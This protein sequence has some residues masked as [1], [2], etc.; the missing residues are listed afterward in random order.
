MEDLKFVERLNEASFLQ[1][2]LVPILDGF[3]EIKAEGMVFLAKSKEN[4]LEQLLTEGFLSSNETFD[5]RLKKVLDET[6][7]SMKSA[8]CDN[9]EKNLKFIEDYENENFKYKVY[10]QDIIVNNKIVRQLNAYFLDEETNVFYEIAL[11]TCPF[12]LNS[13]VILLDFNLED[14]EIT[15]NLYNSFKLLLDLI[16]HNK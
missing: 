14:D 15:K 13:N 3:T 1:N 7:N 16:K 9:P 12:D 2:I 4:Y 8:N 6:I 11:S 5:D 10:L